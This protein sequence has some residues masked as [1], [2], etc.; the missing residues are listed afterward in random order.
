LDFLG[1]GKE[2]VE[3]LPYRAKKKEQLGEKEREKKREKMRKPRIRHACSGLA[4]WLIT[5]YYSTPPDY[6]TIEP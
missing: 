6:L 2:R 4:V 1:G 5:H 3:S